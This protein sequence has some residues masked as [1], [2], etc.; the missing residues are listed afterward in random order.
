M[1]CSYLSGP[2]VDIIVSG[3]RK[4]T[5]SKEILCHVSPFFETAFKP[6]FREGQIGS[7]KFPDAN[8]EAFELAMAF[9]YSNLTGG[10]GGKYKFDLGKFA[11]VEDAITVV[12]HLAALS[13]VLMMPILDQAA[14]CS[15]VALF[16]TADRR[17]HLQVE[18]IGMAYDLLEDKS[19]TRDMITH[20]AAKQFINDA[21]AP[22]SKDITT[23]WRLG[24]AMEKVEGFTYDLL[25]R[26][27]AH[28]E[29]GKRN[30]LVVEIETRD[31][32]PTY[33]TSLW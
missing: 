13:Q 17:K 12:I 29:E 21:W 10:P 33:S 1:T 11:T 28:I 23:A 24:V 20:E 7:L 4:F 6:T 14:S 3:T 9:I 22:K 25:V 27:K 19:R 26:L 30:K 16:H 31:T 8:V 18:H 15:L 32:V 2:Q 5:L